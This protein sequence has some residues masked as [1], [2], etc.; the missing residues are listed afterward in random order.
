MIEGVTIAGHTGRVVIEPITSTDGAASVWLRPPNERAQCVW[1]TASQ[2]RTLAQVANDRAD[3]LAAN[4]PYVCALTTAID[5]PPPPPPTR[6]ARL[7]DF[8][9]IPAPGRPRQETPA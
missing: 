1:L 2:L 6:T 5:P 9:R 8:L 4:E 7:L 3:W